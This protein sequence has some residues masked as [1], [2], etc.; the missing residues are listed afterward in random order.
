MRSFVSTLLIL[1]M[2]IGAG[3]AAYASSRRDNS[4]RYASS[5]HR[6]RSAKRHK[7]GTHRTSTNQSNSKG[8]SNVP[9]NS[10]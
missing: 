3:S 4:P 5:G 7:T 9:E 1:G 10:N 2:T 8:H 6:S